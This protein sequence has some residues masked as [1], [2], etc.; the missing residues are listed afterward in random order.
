MAQAPQGNDD[1][2]F[3]YIVECRD[4]SLYTGITNDLE[5]RLI[6]HNDGTGA[7]YTRS[8]RPV[9]MRYTER[10]ESRSA[11]LVRECAV[12]LLSPKEK[13]ALVEEFQ[14]KLANSD[15]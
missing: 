11:A 8:R 7:R 6:Q 1:L 15:T 2:W 14:R 5:R 10:C 3:V 9:R 12:R 13:R 4:N